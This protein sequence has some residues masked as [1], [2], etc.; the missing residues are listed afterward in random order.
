MA[1]PTNAQAVSLELDRLTLRALQRVYA[2]LNASHFRGSLRTPTLVL[3]DSTQ[4]LGRWQPDDRTIAM[5]RA[6]IAHGWGVAVEVL[7]H[8][9]AHQH[10]GENLGLHGEAHG[11]AFRS[12]CDRLGID[13]RASGLP[14]GTDTRDDATSRLIQKVEKLLS[15]AKSGNEHEAASAMRTAQRMMLKHNPRKFLL[16]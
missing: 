2:E 12:L 13:G 4:F 14:A 16:A 7:K 3:T 15:L 5:T 8:E 1:A 10:V 11:P 6:A 9:M